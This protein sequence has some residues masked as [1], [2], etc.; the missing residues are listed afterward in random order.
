M[1]SKIR[2]HNRMV[3][4]S[5]DSCIPAYCWNFTFSVL[6]IFSELWF[7]LFTFL[8]WRI[9]LQTF[10]KRLYSTDYSK[11]FSF[12][13]FFTWLFYGSKIHQHINS[14]IKLQILSLKEKKTLTRN[15]RWIKFMLLV[16][17]CEKIFHWACPMSVFLSLNE[18]IC[19]LMNEFYLDEF[20]YQK[21]TIFLTLCK[22]CWPF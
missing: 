14:F 3:F 16:E 12:S 1:L 17:C 6:F 10:L 19:N 9:L 7:N 4:L 18:R 13:P 15:A 8:K 2:I 21:P 11:S 20:C 5:V 22:L